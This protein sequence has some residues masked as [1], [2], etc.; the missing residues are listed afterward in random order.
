MGAGWI[1][2]CAPATIANLGPGFDVFALAVRGPADEVAVRPATR[3]SLQVH[4]VEAAGIPS[5]FSGNT[6]GIA[7]EALRAATGISQALEVRVVKGIPPGRGLGSSAGSCAAAA[8]AFLKAFPK[9]RDLGIAGVLRAAVEGEAA[10]AGRHFDNLAGGLR[11]G[12][13][14]LGSSDP[15]LLTREPVRPRIALAIAI[16]NFVLRTADM[17][18]ILP[19][20]VPLPNAVS[21]VGHAAILALGLARGDAALAG[22]C[23]ED[24]FAEPVRAPFLDGYAKA[25][26]AALMAGATGFGLCG[27]GSS[28]FAFAPNSGV[29]GILAEAM[30]EAFRSRGHAATPL[31]TAVDNR[32][33]TAGLLPSFGRRF[34]VLAG[35]G[36]PSISW[37]H[38]PGISQSGLESR[39]DGITGGASRPRTPL[40]RH[41]RTPR[42]SPH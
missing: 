9:S 13:V 25:R 34:S 6:A 26:S 10:V 16:P 1:R 29:A 32:V 39:P 41:A 24:R 5:T 37:G 14:I 19:P 35:R 33:P 21:N 3:D 23:L 38:P 18:K 4:G 22:R 15:L 8:L 20:V 30:C 2:A 40:R 17:R 7:I 27:S 28:V 12:F 42:R 31:V 11:G 36:P